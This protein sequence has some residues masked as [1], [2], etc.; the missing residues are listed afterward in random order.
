MTSATSALTTET[1]APSYTHTCTSSPSSVECFVGDSLQGGTVTTAA[2]SS[3][4][5]DIAVLS[6]APTKPASTTRTEVENCSH[7]EDLEGSHN[8]GAR[9]E[10]QLQSLARKGPESVLQSPHSDSEEGVKWA[11]GCREE[12]VVNVSTVRKDVFSLGGEVGSRLQGEQLD[13]TSESPVDKLED[14]RHTLCGCHGNATNVNLTGL[15]KDSVRSSGLGIA[16]TSLMCV[17]SFLSIAEIA[18]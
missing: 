11:V 4:L 6:T 3:Q 7:F 18:C 2:V 9:H 16:T 15:Q 17:P 8:T 14:S 1:S 12:G 10:C 13:S 5:P